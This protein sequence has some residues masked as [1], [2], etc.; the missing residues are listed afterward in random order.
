[1]G[2]QQQQQQQNKIEFRCIQLFPAFGDEF[3]IRYA[4]NACCELLIKNQTKTKK[5][6]LNYLLFIGTV[7]GQSEEQIIRTRQNNENKDR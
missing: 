2:Q 4:S 3:G 5:E 6:Q 7:Q 1:M